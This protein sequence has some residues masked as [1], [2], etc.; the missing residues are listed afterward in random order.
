[1]PQ[2]YEKCFTE[3]VNDSTFQNVAARM[4]TGYYAYNG[5]AKLCMDKG[6][7]RKAEGGDDCAADLEDVIKG[8]CNL[9]FVSMW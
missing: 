9:N 6:H 5:S 7:S 8:A 1:M 2:D 4:L 3:M